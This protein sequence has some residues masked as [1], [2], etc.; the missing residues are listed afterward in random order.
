MSEIE[1]TD[2][3]WNPLRGCRR[4]SPGCLHCYAERQAS[5]GILSGPGQP[6]EGLVQLTKHGP[7]WTGA[8][9]GPDRLADPLRWKKP[10]KIFV[11]SMS[12]LF[13]EGHTVQQIAQVFGV[14][15]RAQRHIF[16]VLTKRIERA[17]VLLSSPEFRQEVEFWMADVGVPLGE[18]LRWPLPNVWLGTSI[19]QQRYVAPRTLELL[20]TPAAVRFLSLE[21]LLESV[22]LGLMGT[23]PKDISPRYQPVSALL[24][25]VIVGGE[26]GPHARPCCAAWVREVV[27]QCM[28]NAV[29]VFVKQLGAV[30]C[31]TRVGNKQVLI[32]DRKG[33]N[34]EEWPVDLRVRQWPVALTFTAP[35]IASA[36]EVSK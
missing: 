3:T 12:D 32:T 23:I 31:C 35:S 33:G 26:S 15:A 2:V 7:Q 19:E 5:R 6:Y 17:R 29:P 11:C 13:Y 4:V 10:R 30:T 18:E 34:M 20:G 27:I 8:T 25:W 14:M 22:S 21:P 9:A 24:D 28:V 16:Q 1:W 36:Q